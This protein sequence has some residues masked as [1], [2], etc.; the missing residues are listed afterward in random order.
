MKAAI[1]VVEVQRLLVHQSEILHV[2]LY[3]HV[4]ECLIHSNLNYLLNNW[5]HL[6]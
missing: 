1:P 3:G 2:L 4:Q 6:Y 5:E